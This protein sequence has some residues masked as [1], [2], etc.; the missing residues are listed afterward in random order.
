MNAG[1]E[2]QSGSGLQHAKLSRR[3]LREAIG[4]DVMKAI[5]SATAR[6]VADASRERSTGMED[7]SRLTLSGLVGTNTK[8][9]TLQ[10]N[11]ANERG[12][13]FLVEMY[14]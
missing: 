6:P 7:G 12:D 10:V 5:A 2:W 8:T 4:P 11:W 3:I 1:G 9:G 14:S 13:R